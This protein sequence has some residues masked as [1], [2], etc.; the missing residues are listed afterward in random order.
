[1][2]Q[3]IRDLEGPLTEEIMDHVIVRRGQLRKEFEDNCTTAYRAVAK[4]ARERITLRTEWSPEIEAE[5][6][7]RLSEAVRYTKFTPAMQRALKA[8]HDF[9]FDFAKHRLRTEVEMMHGLWNSAKLP[10]TIFT[11]AVV[12]IGIYRWNNQPGRPPA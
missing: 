7:G 8:T 4:E 3:Q 11:L 10:V 5:W 6:L 2:K 1:L 9:W 12:V